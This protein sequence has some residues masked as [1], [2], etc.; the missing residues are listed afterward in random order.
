MGPMVSIMVDL[1]KP[2]FKVGDVIAS[3]NDNGQVLDRPVLI[4][5][6]TNTKGWYTYTT[7]RQDPEDVKVNGKIAKY[8]QASVARFKVVGFSAAA[9]TL[10]S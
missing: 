9:A 5:E 2:I 10:F 1:L 6:V 4:V 7:I 3:F 8:T